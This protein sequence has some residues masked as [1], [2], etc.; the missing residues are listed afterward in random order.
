MSMRRLTRRQTADCQ[1]LN[2]NQGTMTEARP[3][4]RP[5]LDYHISVLPEE[6][7]AIVRV[8]HY[9]NGKALEVDETVIFEDGEEGFEAFKALVN[10]SLACGANVS[11]SSG[12]DPADLGIV[13]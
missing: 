7:F 12:Y 3:P 4:R 13:S 5:V 2:N 9:Q 1:S 10:T 6:I 11:I 8:S